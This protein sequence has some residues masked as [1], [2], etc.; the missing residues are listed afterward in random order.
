MVVDGQIEA[1]P[2]MYLAL[3][4]DHRIVDGRE[5]VQFL[6]AVKDPRRS[7]A[8]LA[9]DLDHA[10]DL[11]IRTI[12]MN[13]KHYDVVVIG[14]GPAGYPGRDPR[15]QNKLSA[16]CIDEWKNEDGT[17]AFGGTCLNAGCIPVQGAARVLRALSPRADGVR[18]AR[19][20][21]RRARPRRRDDAEAQGGH[22]QAAHARHRRRCSRRPA[23]SGCKGHGKLLAGNRVEVKT[24]DGSRDDLREAR[25]ARDR[26]RA[27]RAADRRRSTA[28]RS[29]IRWGAL[30]FTS[31]P[32]RLGV[33]GAGVIG[34]E[35][36][37]VWRRLGSEVV[38]LEALDTLPVM[39]DQQIAKEALRHF[40]KQGLDI[41]LGAKV[42]GADVRRDG[43]EVNYTDAAGEQ[44]LEVDK[45][46]VA[47]GRR[48]YTTGS[49]RRRHGRAARRARLHQGRSRVPHRRCRTSGRSAMCVR[50]P[51]LAHKG[52]EEGV[53]VAD[54]IAG[55]FGEVN[56]KTIPSVIYTAPEIAWVGQTEEQVKKSGRPIQGRHVPVS[57]ER[58]RARD[59]APPGFVQ[60][61]CG[62]GRRRDPRRAHHRPGGRRADRRGRARDGV[63]G[64]HRGPAADHPCAPDALRGVA[65][66]RARRGQ[67][68]D[69]C[70]QSV[71]RRANARA[72]LPL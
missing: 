49:A 38:V 56:Y 4:Y 25:R 36:G 68:R 24:D 34:L 5:A 12:A 42:T 35:L 70:H 18:G 61:D 71:S 72:H 51:M 15:R 57:G 67:A 52:K 10:L 17:R 27:D 50:G 65:R 45:L 30:E 23:S 37:S 20:Q 1:R 47:I 21:G 31:V 6:V 19:H 66:S 13:D 58:P 29:S 26:L 28:S 3:T 40:K 32:K 55:Q 22:R 16:A 33:I 2:M 60:G 48:P 14:G 39:A 69:P 63:L 8:P 59:G 54:L 53:M 64:E 41:R 9:S 11:R 46:V 7:G 62:E 44:T 43:V